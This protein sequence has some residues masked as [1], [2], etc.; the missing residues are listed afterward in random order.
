MA[1]LYVVPTPIGNLEDISLRA[2]KVIFTVPIILAEDTRRSAN[3]LSYFR[4]QERLLESLQ[5]SAEHK[6]RYLSLHEYNEQSRIPQVMDLLSQGQDMALLSDAGTPLISDPG[7][8]LIRQVAHE[9]SHQVVPLPGPTAWVTALVGSGLPPNR[10]LFVGFLPAKQKARL[11]ELANLQLTCLKMKHVPTIVVYESAH[12][13]VT[14]LRDLAKVA[15]EIEIVIAQE[16][17]KLHEKFWYL[18]ISQAI[19]QFKQF[20]RPK[21]EY[22]LVFRFASGMGE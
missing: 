12:R 14:S 16:M 10:V 21:G 5:L 1:K 22:T 17:T 19:N 15:G 4:Q 13:L 3:L 20:K 2:L 8:K 9:S 7:F 11:K 6:P 18:P